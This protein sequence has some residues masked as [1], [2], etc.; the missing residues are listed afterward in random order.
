MK[1][2]F[3]W[4]LFSVSPLLMCPIIAYADVIIEPNYGRLYSWLPYPFWIIMVL[5]VVTALLIR[6]F[7]KKK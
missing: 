5:V 3:S 2:F 6:L 7:R 4:L 1:R